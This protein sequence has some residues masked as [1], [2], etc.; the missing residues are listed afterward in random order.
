MSFLLTNEASNLTED[1]QLTGDASKFSISVKG[2][3][4]TKVEIRV[5]NFADS[6]DTWNKIGEAEVGAGETFT[7]GL[8]STSSR[9][10][11]FLI[12]EGSGGALGRAPYVSIYGTS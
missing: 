8:F 10:V 4:G 7:Y 9:F 6:P 11:G 1:Y 3:V 5:N 12:T 2:A